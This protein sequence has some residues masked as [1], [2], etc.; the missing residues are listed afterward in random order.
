MA[1]QEN[2]KAVAK[3]E[4]TIMVMVNCV[5]QK[6]VIPSAKI[7]SVQPLIFS[8]SSLLS[9]LQHKLMFIAIAYLT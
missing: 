5:Q 6:T 8:S 9:I 2:K 1:K 7:S 3:A 4:S